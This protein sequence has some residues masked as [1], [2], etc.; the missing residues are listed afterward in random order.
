MAWHRRHLGRGLTEQDCNIR[1]RFDSRRAA[2][3]APPPAAAAGEDDDR[4]TAR[5]S[6]KKSR[7]GEMRKIAPCILHHLDQL[8]PIVLDHFPVDLHH[9]FGRQIGHVGDA[10]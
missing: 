1:A 3:S 9:L 4:A 10:K 8:D 5:I 2:T 7:S 6:I